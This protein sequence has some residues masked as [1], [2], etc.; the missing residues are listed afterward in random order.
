MT[1][2]APL[3]AKSAPNC[4]ATNLTA[5]YGVSS[6]TWL[7]TPSIDLT[8]ATAATLVFQH[9]VDIDDLFLGESGTVRVLDATMLP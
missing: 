7:R 4:Y 8:T 1:L 6:N 5:D 2:T 3:A 9:W